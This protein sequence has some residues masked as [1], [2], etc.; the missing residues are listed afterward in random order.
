MPRTYDLALSFAGEQRGIAERLATRLDAAG[1]AVFY[2]EFE[3]ARLWGSELPVS[4]GEVYSS[5]ARFCLII[6][7]SEYVEKMWTNVER[8]FAISRALEERSEYI[9]PVRV[10][11]SAL[12]G[13][14][15]TTAYVDLRRLDEDELYHLLLQKLGA[16][17]HI[18]SQADVSAEDR[19]RA[20][21][22]IAACYRRAVFTKMDSEIRL[23]AMFQSLRDALGMVQRI[24]P[25]FQALDL[26]NDGARI[27]AELD[28][29]ERLHV[30][31]REDW[32]YSLSRDTRDAMD[33][34]KL[35]IVQL[36][37]RIRRRAR[38]PMQLP[39]NLMFDH[40]Y[41]PQQAA[42]A[43]DPGKQR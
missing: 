38:I 20:R 9:L 15:S 11:D 29:L 22:L 30:S 33:A 34:A 13:L 28:N 3:T 40:F 10:D 18:S 16:P 31:R 25:T 1:Y 12:P 24:V 41:S 4:L 39:T 26:Q 6:S 36:L 19:S 14:A 7:S 35:R 23:D 43:P 2:D 42:A 27:I 5:A 37:L 8:R 32:S 21:A 17:D